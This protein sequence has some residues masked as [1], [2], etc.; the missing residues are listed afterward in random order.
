MQILN[1]QKIYDFVIYMYIINYLPLN[2]YT[3]IAY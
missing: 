1:F 3:I 2:Q